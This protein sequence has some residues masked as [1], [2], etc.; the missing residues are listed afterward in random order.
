MHF[1]LYEKTLEWT[2][3]KIRWKL[4]LQIVQASVIEESEFNNI[5]IFGRGTDSCRKQ[6]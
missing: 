3:G 6:N 1:H 2:T 4:Y 5:V